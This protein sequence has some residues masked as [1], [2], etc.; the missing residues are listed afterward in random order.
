MVD[1]RRTVMAVG[2]DP[3]ALRAQPAD[4]A[5][6]VAYLRPRAIATLGREDGD[7]RQVSAD[8]A[9]GWLKSSDVWGLAPG[10]Q[11]R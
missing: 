10:A 7:W 3:V 5:A 9:S 8:G 11:C 2:K 6:V 4:T 1:G